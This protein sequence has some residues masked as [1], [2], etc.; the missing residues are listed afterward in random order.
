MSRTIGSSDEYTSF[1]TVRTNS[2]FFGNFRDQAQT[3]ENDELTK[4]SFSSQSAI[5]SNLTYASVR[6]TYVDG[7]SDMYLALL[8]NDAVIAGEIYYFTTLE[9][10]RRNNRG[11]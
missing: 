8:H 5:V 7:R 11:R 2:R 9:K 4:K 10:R 1:I 6:A 3:R